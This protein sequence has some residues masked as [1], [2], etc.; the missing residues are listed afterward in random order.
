M[1]RSFKT[2]SL[3][4]QFFRN[5]LFRYKRVLG[6]KLTCVVQAKITL[7]YLFVDSQDTENLFFI[8]QTTL[9]DD[10]TNIYSENYKIVSE[11]EPIHYAIKN[12][13]AKNKTT[14]P[15]KIHMCTL[16]FEMHCFVTNVHLEVNSHAQA[17]ITQVYLFDGT[18]KTQKSCLHCR[19]LL[20]MC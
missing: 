4:T 15:L 19:K 10:N 14:R 6:G 20:K 7:V 17:K 8:P 9:G 3:C 12:M 13:L 1:H 18:Q 2:I 16:F 5:A 11:Y